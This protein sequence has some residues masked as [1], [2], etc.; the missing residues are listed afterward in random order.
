MN[1]ELNVNADNTWN[2][3]IMFV[4]LN[5][6]RNSFVLPDPPDPSDPS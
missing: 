4:N 6:F 1:C 5:I 3:G 2:M